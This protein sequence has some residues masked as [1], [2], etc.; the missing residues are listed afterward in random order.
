MPTPPS[1]PTACPACAR[2]LRIVYLQTE[3]AHARFERTN[4]PDF[5]G[6]RLDGGAFLG[7]PSWEPKDTELG[8]YHVVCRDCGH[9]AGR[10]WALVGEAP[11]EDRTLDTK[12]EAAGKPPKRPYLPFDEQ[13]ATPPWLQK[14]IVYCLM[15]TMSLE[16]GDTMAEALAWY[17]EV[18]QKH[19]DRDDAR[20]AWFDGEADTEGEVVVTTFAPHEDEEGVVVFDTRGL[21]EVRERWSRGDDDAHPESP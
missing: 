12:L 6:F 4:G 8:S 15:I 11:V 3:R 14:D 9:E 2:P 7:S 5:P 17:A 10:W 19:A 21:A 20:Q 1:P 18:R 16:W 13:L